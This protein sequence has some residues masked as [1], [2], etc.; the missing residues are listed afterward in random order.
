MRRTTLNAQNILSN[1]PDITTVWSAIY[2][3]GTCPLHV[4]NGIMQQCPTTAS[5]FMWVA[6]TYRTAKAMM[7]HPYSHIVKV[8][9]ILTQPR[10]AE[11]NGGLAAALVPPSS[12]S[13][14]CYF[15]CGTVN[16][17]VKLVQK[18]ISFKCVI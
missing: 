17:L 6:A 12:S 9:Q 15:K 11:R 5:I 10:N 4:V 16:R 2:L 18:G 14:R 7:N 13:P 3:K 1:T 8:V